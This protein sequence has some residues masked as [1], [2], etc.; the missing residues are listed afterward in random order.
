MRT[1]GRQNF[2][3]A[4]PMA[5]WRKEHGKLTQQQ[6][7]ELLGMSTIGVKNIEIGITPYRMIHM[8]ALEALHNRMGHEQ[9]GV[10]SQ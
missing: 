9:P 1:D 8:L 10:D 5:Q 4:S 3:P 7:A 6:L 2:N